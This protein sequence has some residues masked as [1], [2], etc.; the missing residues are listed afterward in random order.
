MR[1]RPIS[2]ILKGRILQLNDEGYTL[3]QIQEKLG[4]PRSTI[5]DTIRRFLKHHTTTPL[6]H[7][8][9]P[10]AL[11]ER[12]RRRILRTIKE[13]RVLPYKAVAEL[14]GEVTERQVRRV[15]NE[16][17]YHRR[18]ARWKPYLSARVVQLRLQWAR[19]NLETDWDCV[20]W[21]DEMRIELGEQPTCQRVTRRL[22]EELLRENIQP[23][24]HS[25]RQSIMVWGVIANGRKGP[26]VVLDFTK[27]NKKTGKRKK[28]GGLTGERYVKQVLEGPLLAFLRELE[29]ERGCPVLVVEDGAGP[30]RSACA[31]ACREKHGM[32]RLTHPPSSPDL[33][34][35]EPLWHLIKRRVAASKGAYKSLS[36]LREAVQHVWDGISDE[37]IRQYT[38]RMPERVQA[39]RKANGW[40]TLF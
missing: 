38:G 28:K 15:A 33:N 39:V 25:G 4:V 3:R 29:E 20:I 37:E 22:G 13:H 27:L 5:N 10:Q 34:P 16:A 8:G 12:T 35:I 23:T 36:A 18:I 14:V 17:G 30:H 26:L 21:T 40:H 9:R 7:T 31:T 6:P 2:L 11:D 24:F 32:L 1:G 19:N